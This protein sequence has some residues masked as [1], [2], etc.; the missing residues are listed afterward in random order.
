MK[1]FFRNYNFKKI[2]Q[3]NTIYREIMIII[4]R[5]EDL[6][7]GKNRVERNTI[8]KT[9]YNNN[10]YTESGYRKSREAIKRQ[11]RA[12]V[13]ILSLSHR[14][15]SLL[16]NERGNVAEI[17]DGAAA[18]HSHFESLDSVIGP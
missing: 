16:L 6:E 5:K 2:E 4:A 7:K 15:V 14:T 12:L 9:Q 13:R 1:F 3:I 17:N 18:V 10:A 11:A 8:G